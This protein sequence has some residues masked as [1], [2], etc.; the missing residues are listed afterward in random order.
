MAIKVS[1][2][3]KNPGNPRQIKGEKL[4]LLKK[5]V[6]T[7]QKMMELRP[8]IVDENNVVLG[9]NMRLAA[10]K[11]LGLKE[12][13]DTWVK[14]VELSED[15]KREF[16]IK[17]NAGFGEWDWDDL[18]N[19]WSDLPLTEWGLDVPGFEAIEPEGDADAE[20]QIDKAAELNKKWKVKSGDLWQIGSHRLICGDSTD[21]GCVSRLMD[22]ERAELLFTSPP[23]SDQR[24]YDGESD[25][26]IEHLVRFIPAFSPH[27]RYQ[28]VNLGIKRHG[29]E[30]VPYWDAYILEARS[31]GYKLLSWNVWNQGQVGSVGKLTAMFPIEHEWIFVFGEGVK[32]INPTVPNK[33]AGESHGH[34]KDRQADGSTVKKKSI[35]IRDKREIG[36]VTEL[37]CV[38][39]RNDLD[40]LH[41]ASFPKELPMTY[42][43]AMTDSGQGVCE[44][45]AGSGTTLVACQNLNRKCYA[46]EISENYC[47]VILERMQTAFP[48]IEIK[49][50]ED[51]EKAN[52]GRATKAT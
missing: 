45:F 5:S 15:E 9:G 49:R 48:D 24:D 44:P 47:A 20:P 11:A 38:L 2:L 12:I 16:I 40:I 7:F 50:L 43:E 31:A 13:P 36:T 19:N 25:L 21:A 32:D 33:S 39:A 8:I 28:V 3:K 41:S 51:G 23:Y 10:I 34:V 42:I 27:C 14:Q 30:V 1:K 46:I 17:D 29:G 22:G 52:K 26:S 18:A 6:A 37:N 4:E 35:V